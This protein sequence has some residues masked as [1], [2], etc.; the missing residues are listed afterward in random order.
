MEK[1]WQETLSDIL[2]GYFGYQSLEV[3]VKEMIFVTRWNQDYH[4]R[5]V[6]AIQSGITAA[7]QGNSEV[8]GIIRHSLARFVESTEEAQQFLNELLSE[9]NVQYSIASNDIPAKPST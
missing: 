7:S 2:N 4:Q 1:T 9:Y 3:G 8:I 6:A 5:Y